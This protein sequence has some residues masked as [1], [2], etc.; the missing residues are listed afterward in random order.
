MDPNKNASQSYADIHVLSKID[1]FFDHFKLGTLLHRCGIRKRHGHTV[2]S[3]IE[4]IFTLPFV[5]KNFFRGIV[6]N[7]ALAFSKDAAYEVLKGSAYNW[8]RLLLT[9]GCRLYAFFNRLT[10]EERESVLIIDDSPYDRSRSKMVELLCR[11]WDHST[12]RYLKGFRMLTICWSDGTSCLPLD[13]SL[14]S[15]SQEKKRLCDSRKTLDK[16]CC[17]YQ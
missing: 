11:V 4:T 3:L 10:G 12:R 14:L 13:F 16:R 8:R 17:A 2:R 1:D 15:A 9:L 6:T 5:G 7:E